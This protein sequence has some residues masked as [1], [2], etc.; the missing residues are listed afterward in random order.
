VKNF[1]NMFLFMS[2]T[3]S[4]FAAIGAAVG[5]VVYAAMESVES[6]VTDSDNMHCSCDP[7]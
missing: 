3:F 4:V 5:V 1:L 2:I 7:R 6:M